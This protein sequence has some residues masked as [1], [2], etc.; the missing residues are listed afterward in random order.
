[1][2]QND[3]P[4]VE[5]IKSFRCTFDICNRNVRQVQLKRLPVGPVIERN[6]TCRIR[7]PRRAILRGQDLRAPRAWANLRER[8]SYR[9][10]GEFQVLAIIGGVGAINVRL[11]ITE[12]SSD[13]PQE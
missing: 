7:F 13:R 11:V 6:K 8:R 5:T 1:M 2:I 4:C 3:R 10:S 9:R 12:Q